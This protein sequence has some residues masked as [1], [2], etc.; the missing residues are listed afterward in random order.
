MLP[1]LS[2]FSSPQTQ[3]LRTVG[4]ELPWSPNGFYSTLPVQGAWVPA[5]VGELD[6]TCCNE[7]FTDTTEGS[8]TPQLRPS[9][10]S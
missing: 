7:E 5:L 2:L 8:P 10:A 6:P 3:S 9:T 4:M 1:N